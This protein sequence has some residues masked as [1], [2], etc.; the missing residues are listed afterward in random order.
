MTATPQIPAELSTGCRELDI[1]WTKFASAILDRP[2][3]LIPDNE[4]DLNWHAFLGH[5]IDMQ[6]FRA[7]EFA[8]VDEL[9]KRAP[10]FISLKQRGI[11]VRELAGLWAIPGLREH[12][13]VGTKGVSFSVT[14]DELRSM[15]GP[16]G[17]SLAEAFV[18]FP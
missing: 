18:A 1:V 8:G 13:L 16:V 4:E 9:T 2:G 17:E 12:L 10:E 6:G 14:L 11:G 15:G 3:I 7:A 5:S